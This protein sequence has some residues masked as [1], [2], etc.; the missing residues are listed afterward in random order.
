MGEIIGCFVSR[1]EWSRGQGNERHKREGEVLKRTF[2]L[3]L[4]QHIPKHPY[5]SPVS[6]YIIGNKAKAEGLRQSR[7]LVAPQSPCDAQYI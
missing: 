6:F 2:L 3:P 1:G 7:P 5:S 4:S